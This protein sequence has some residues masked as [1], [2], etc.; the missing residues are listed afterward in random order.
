MQV[1]IQKL[2]FIALALII[3]SCGHEGCIDKSAINY[4]STADKDDGSCIYC[5]QDIGES[6]ILASNEYFL[7]DDRFGS[8]HAFD[9]VI[10]ITVDQTRKEYMNELCGT[11]FC[12]FKVDLQNLV[13]EDM[14]NVQFNFTIENEQGPFFQP[15]TFQLL[16]E[17][18]IESGQSVDISFSTTNVQEECP[19]L[20]E[21]QLQNSSIFSLVYL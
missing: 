5:D 10:K 21:N 17:E 2:F 8:E 7:I 3:C 13:E 1:S 19:G 20:N 16:N 14:T 11:D 15:I 6:S 18:S 4:D 9:T 12:S